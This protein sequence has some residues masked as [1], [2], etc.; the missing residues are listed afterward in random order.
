MLEEILQWFGQGLMSE[1]NCEGVQFEFF[2]ELGDELEI[3]YILE[4]L[5]QFLKEVL[6]LMVF[7]E[8]C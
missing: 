4:F 1:I 6:L 7:V 8:D 3:G 2:E 5:F